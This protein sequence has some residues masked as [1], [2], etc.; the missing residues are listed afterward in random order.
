[1][2][3]P[4]RCHGAVEDRR[5]RT[6]TNAIAMVWSVEVVELY[7]AAKAAIERGAAG[8]VVAPEDETPVLGENRLL[9]ALHEAVGP[10]VARLDPRLPDAERGAGARGPAACVR[11][12]SPPAWRCGARGPAT[13]AA[14]WPSRGGARV[15][16]PCWAPP[17]T[18]RG[19]GRSSPAA[20]RPRS[21]RRSR[22]PAVAARRP[23]AAAAPG[24]AGRAAAAGAARPRRSDSSVAASDRTACAKFPPRG[25]P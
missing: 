22:R 7:K 6:A 15:A 10:G 8:E 24:P 18:A 2:W 16:G 13:A 5:R 14:A 12:T 9:Q 23:A 21:P 17:A 25:T 3:L 19:A 1:M 11:S 20:P 4:R